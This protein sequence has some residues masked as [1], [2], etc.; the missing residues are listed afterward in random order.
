MKI[1]LTADVHLTTQAKHPERYQ[2]LANIYQ[3]CGE[4][5]VQ[6][7]II[8]G[9]LFNQ[10]LANY[11]D[12]EKLYKT[13]RPPDLTTVII[14]GNHDHLLR[15][16]EFSGDGLIIYSDPIIKPLNNSRKV[17]F[18][19]YMANRTM[20]QAIAP[21]SE[22]LSGQRWILIGHGDWTAGR[23]TP[24]PYEH[25]VYMPLTRADLQIYQPELVFLGHIHLAQDGK[26]VFYPGSPCPL[27]ISETG[28]RRFLTFDTEKGEIESH[29]ID[30]P[31]IYFSE[32]FVVL[33]VENDLDCLKQEIKE[34]IQNWNLP[35]GWKNRV[36]VR[37]E[38]AGTAF[39]D[40]KKILSLTK[41][42]FSEYSF[43]KKEDPNLDGL[44][45][46]PDPDRTEISIQAQDWLS[47]LDWNEEGPS[48][49][50][51]TQILE[52][53]LKIIYRGVK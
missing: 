50:S 24:D 32:R 53:A 37:V 28:L 4:N 31:L 48:T 2:A 22:E 44:I 42:A 14:P 1:A 27:N 15:T 34:R 8:A 45:H 18:L 7:L 19:P 6:L 40:R 49:P 3:Q 41:K 12:F 38:I 23:N 21:F 35:T 25:G 13:V 20:G 9:D 33:P 51:E 10:T 39:S 30:S 36:Q 16:E 5:Q 47:Q 29:L 46:N 43:Y 52:A 11:A 17:L 26:E